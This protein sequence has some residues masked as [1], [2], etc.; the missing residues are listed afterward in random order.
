MRR[1]ATVQGTVLS[2]PG[3]QEVQPVNNPGFAPHPMK[4]SFPH[5]RSGVALA[6]LL[7]S[8]WVGMS[9][10]AAPGPSGGGGGGGQGGA[11]T[12]PGSGQNSGGSGT[13]RATPRQTDNPNAGQG[14]GSNGAA[15]Q[16]GNTPS[17]TGSQ[18]QQPGAAANQN[19]PQ[20]QQQQG[21]G[22]NPGIQQ[23]TGA[24]V[25]LPGQGS[26]NSSTTVQPGAS[27]NQNSP[28][29]QQQGTG[30]NSG[31]QQQT[32]A[33]STT[34]IQPGTGQNSG[35]SGTQTPGAAAGVTT[36]NPSGSRPGM[37]GGTIGVGATG[38][39]GAFDTNGFSLTGATGGSPT[40]FLIGPGTT[41]TDEQGREMPRTR[42]SNQNATVY[43]TRTGNDLVATRVVANSSPSAAAPAPIS[44]AGTI[45]EVSPGV[46]VIEQAAASSTPVRYVNDQTTNYVNQNGEPVS[47]ESVKAGTPVRVFYTK[48]GDTLVASRVEVQQ[49]D[50]GLP[51]PPVDAE[52]T[53]TIPRQD[54]R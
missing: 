48:V 25:Q 50:S 4:P 41:F 9:Q 44:S 34:A 11:N 31:I 26:V 2:A 53:T 37:T 29:M 42:F 47:A 1:K 6:A 5:F 32:G 14:S 45:R 39:I 18:Q 16:S 15:Q 28:Q 35:V 52:G 8:P 21:T 19:S 7:A 22:Q 43:Y 51:K 40:S 54:N 3:E 10:T 36:Q 30:Q 49:G 20:M 46:L 17:G 13:N 27:S 12:R 23:Q 33:G 38:M 24:G